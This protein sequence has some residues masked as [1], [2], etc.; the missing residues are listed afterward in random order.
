[1]A[2]I[3]SAETITAREPSAS[4]ATSRKAPRTFRLSFWPR[5]S[6]DS[7]TMFATRPIAPKTTVGPAAVSAGVT[8]RSIASYR[9]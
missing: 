3:T 1:M 8:N 4:A 5:I 9:T 6:S 2:R 7:D